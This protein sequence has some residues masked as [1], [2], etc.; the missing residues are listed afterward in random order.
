MLAHLR[1]GETG[2]AVTSLETWVARR[3]PFAETAEEGLEGPIYTRRHVLQHLGVDL[4]ILSSRASLIP[5]NSAF[6]W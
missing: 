2:V 5:G 3:L 1:I 4:S 6:C